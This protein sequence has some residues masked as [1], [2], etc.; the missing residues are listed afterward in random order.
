MGYGDAVSIT[1]IG[2]AVNTASRLEAMTK[3]LKCQ[4]I[5]SAD[6]ETRSKVDLE[7]FSCCEV[8][9]RGRVEP[10][11]IRTID[12]SSSLPSLA[13]SAAKS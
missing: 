7:A 2:D 10:L 11:T 8:N 4:L 5:V 13:D 12:K 1:A 6:V 9:L 3:E